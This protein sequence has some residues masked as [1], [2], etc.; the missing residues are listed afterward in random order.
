MVE[1]EK[2]VC[3][4][5]RIEIVVWS[6]TIFSGLVSKCHILYLKLLFCRS[7]RNFV[8]LYMT[9]GFNA[10]WYT[11]NFRLDYRWRRFSLCSFHPFLSESQVTSKN[12][13]DVLEGR[14]GWVYK[15]GQYDVICSKMHVSGPK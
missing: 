15:V 14:V 13:F 4:S 1:V 7:Y 9:S 5:I 6:T 12:V 2:R 8:I 10:L 3:Y 11:R